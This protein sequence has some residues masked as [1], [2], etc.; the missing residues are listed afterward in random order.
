MLTSKTEVFRTLAQHQAQLAAF[1]VARYGVFGSFVRNQVTP[2]SDVD[3][4]VEFRP[5]GKTFENFMNLAWFLEELLG[6]PVDLVT[7]ESLSPYLG[8]KILREV[9]YA[10]RLA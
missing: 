2:D 8:P 1:G 9:E 4:L 10:P 7:T 5:G 3:L 6:R